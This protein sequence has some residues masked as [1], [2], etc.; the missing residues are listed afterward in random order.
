[1]IA[2][3]ANRTRE[4][5]PERSRRAI[6]LPPCTNLARWAGAA[7]GNYQVVLWRTQTSRASCARS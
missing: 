7:A 5:R 1:V 3:S 2:A 6:S 4:L